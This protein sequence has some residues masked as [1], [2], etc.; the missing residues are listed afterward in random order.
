MKMKKNHAD[1]RKKKGVMEVI[2]LY[3]S[4]LFFVIVILLMFVLFGAGSCSRQNDTKII[5][6]ITEGEGISFEFELEEFLAREVQ[7]DY[8][9]DGKDDA[10]TISQLISIFDSVMENSL[11]TGCGGYL[12]FS[13]HWQYTIPEK[14]QQ[15]AKEIESKIL[16]EFDGFR[17]G[18]WKEDEK[19]AWLIEIYRVEK[20]NAVDGESEKK[21]IIRGW[22]SFIT[23]HIEKYTTSATLPSL[24]DDNRIIIVRM[25]HAKGF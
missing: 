10:V 7:F 2:F 20:H 9:N 25:H 12:D 24:Y 6:S 23:S 17:K 15:L 11:I 1:K 16:T 13:C 21:M 5:N 22:Y 3:F 4:F 18:L 8:D 14:R 19:S